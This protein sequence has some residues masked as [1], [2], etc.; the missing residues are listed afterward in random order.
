MKKEQ[1]LKKWLRAALAVVLMVSQAPVFARAAAIDAYDEV[2][3]LKG[4]ILS[5]PAKGVTRVSVTN[6]D[7]ADVA[8]AKDT[9]II[10][11]GKEV[12]EAVL[13]VWDQYGKRSTIIHVIDSDLE[14]VRDRILALLR[15]AGI[16]GVNVAVSA[17][18]AKIVATGMLTESTMKV[19]D[20]IVEPFGDKVIKLVK[21]E[22]IE[23]LIQIDMQV[24][25]LKTTLSK[26][27]GID[28][29]TGAAA[30]TGTFA[31]TAGSSLSPQ[32]GEK[33]IRQSGQFE[34]LFKIASFAR[35]NSLVAQ[36]N[37][38]VEEGK[39]KILSKPKLVV[40]NGKEATF[41]VGGEIPIKTSTLSTT[42]T[43]ENVEFKE[44]GIT[45]ALTPTIRDGKVDT[46][47]SV[48]ISDV[49]PAYNSSPPAF[50]TRSAQTQLFLDDK[51][52]II[53]AGMIR[54]AS[55]ITE[56]RVPMLGK[57]PVLGA[58]FRTR[59]NSTSGSPDEESEIV[60]T[61]TPTILRSVKKAAPSPYAPEQIM[62]QPQ[63]PAP[64]ICALQAEDATSDG[65]LS[66]AAFAD[67]A[68]EVQCK[69]SNSIVYPLE[70]QRAWLQ[71][72]VKLRIVISSD[73]NIKDA[74][75]AESSGVASLDGD[76]LATAKKAAPFMPLP[77]DIKRDQVTVTIPI[78][79]SL[80]SR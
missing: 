62:V 23:D 5:V 60:I 20:Q 42:G 21:Q 68:R 57:I 10:V 28:W 13:F 19:F 72:T 3:L 61:M 22:V 38:F 6:P 56:K 66:S 37:M 48:E 7:I 50:I 34:D 41:L 55:S 71:G 40:V 70:A 4:D 35:T 26:E 25:E 69:I 9:E 29:S 39:A 51:Q 46:L 11:S 67:Y 18:E 31:T 49:D 73:G 36:I 64:A 79:Y 58:L 77:L 78:A 15:T 2:Q 76:A 45:L 44:Y 52:T 24:T 17:Q 80:G 53:L 33:G 16:S 32:Y 75:V 43:S 14:V 27:L 65:S 30:A 63:S 54:K 74:Y 8:E 47:L 12:G 1:N 59:G